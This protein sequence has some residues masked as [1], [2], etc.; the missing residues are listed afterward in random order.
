MD[1]P[2]IIRFDKNYDKLHGQ[3]VATVLEVLG[4]DGTTLDKLSNLIDYCTAYTVKC[5]NGKKETLYRPL[6]KYK[7]YIIIVLLGWDYIPFT[8]IRSYSDEDYQ[9]Y[10]DMKGKV[11]KIEVVE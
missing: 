6:N 5:D 9:K 10:T 4:I 1:N 7:R 2:N 11:V 3:K 8:T